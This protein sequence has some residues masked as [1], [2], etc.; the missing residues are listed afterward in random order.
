VDDEP[1]TT[2]IGAVQVGDDAATTA[3]VAVDDVRVTVP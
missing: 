1:G 2:A 3:T